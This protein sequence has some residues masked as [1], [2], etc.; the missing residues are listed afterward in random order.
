[1]PDTLAPPR[2]PAALAREMADTVAALRRVTVLVRSRGAG[3]GAGVVWDADGLVITNAHVARGD[4]VVVQFSDGTTAAARVVARDRQR[5]LAAL[6]LESPG[7]LS[8]AV[9]RTE[10]SLRVGDL[11]IAVGHP[12]G[13]AAAVTVGIIHAGDGGTGREPRWVRAD[14]RLAP[15][16]SG[17]PLADAAGHV[18]GINTLIYGG[19]ALAVPVAAVRAWLDASRRPT[20]AARA[21]T[22]RRG[23]AASRRD[24]AGPGRSAR[25]S[26]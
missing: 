1:M 18:V 8:A 23:K 21:R 16:Y 5:D 12:G 2:A 26:S 14:V 24:G 15:G 20:H 13:Q 3:V 22:G 6:E 10:P 25:S 9:L 19:L 4:Q 7:A 11:A 17:G